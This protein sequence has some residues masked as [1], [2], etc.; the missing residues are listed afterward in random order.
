MGVVLCSDHTAQGKGAR[1]LIKS[2]KLAGLLPCLSYACHTHQLR[3]EVAHQRR[4]EMGRKVL[5]KQIQILEPV[6][7]VL[8]H[9]LQ[10]DR[11]NVITLIKA[12]KGIHN[13][14]RTK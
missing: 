12:S 3:R 13:L 5:S 8:V 10:P 7:K 4:L 11:M 9:W 6:V 1:T 14:Q 2:P